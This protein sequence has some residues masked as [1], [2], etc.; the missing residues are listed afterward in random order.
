MLELRDEDSIADYGPRPYAVASELL[1]S[2]IEAQT[3]GQY[4][5]TLYGQPTRKAE[6]KTEVS[7]QLDYAGTLELSDRVE[8]VS[9]GIGTDMY[10]ESIGHV[11]R[12]GFR[13]DMR[14]TMSQAGLFDDVIILDGGPGLDTGILGA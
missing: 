8:Y 14:I 5:L 12:P 6:V 3:Y 13:H 2:V 10:I 11:L 9:R 7:D 1:S 4:I